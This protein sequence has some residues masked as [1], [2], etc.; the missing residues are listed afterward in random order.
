MPIAFSTRNVP[1]PSGKGRREINESTTFGSRVR[2][3]AVAINGFKLDYVDSDHHI[4]VVEID[5]DVSLIEENEVHF[6]VEVHYADKDF[7]DAY[8]GY[9]QVLVIANVD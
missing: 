1:I 2:S 4:N 9:V 7:N 5:S 6:L 3:A 8:Q